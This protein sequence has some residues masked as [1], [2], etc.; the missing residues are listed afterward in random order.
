M[1]RAHSRVVLASGGDVAFGEMLVRLPLSPQD[2]DVVSLCSE[3]AGWSDELLVRP[4]A[5]AKGK[6][7]ASPAGSSAGGSRIALALRMG[8]PR[9][10]SHHVAPSHVAASHVATSHVAAAI[11][12]PKAVAVAPTSHGAPVAVAS[13]A[14]P[15]PV[16]LIAQAPVAFRGPPVAPH[17]AAVTVDQ[18]LDEAR[19]K[20]GPPAPSHHDAA[21]ADPIPIAS[22]PGENRVDRVDRPI[23]AICQDHISDNPA[24]NMCLPCGHVFHAECTGRLRQVAEQQG[25][26]LP[27]NYCSFRCHE[28]NQIQNHLA[29]NNAGGDGA[30]ND[31][32]EVV[33]V[34]CT[35]RI[36]LDADDSG[37]FPCGHRYHRVCGNGP[38]RD[39][40]PYRCHQFPGPHGNVADPSIANADANANAAAVEQD[41]QEIEELF[42]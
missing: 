3:V 12:E 22:S 41:R 25:R 18:L 32:G 21:L 34:F 2:H 19:S 23:C 5:K 31:G 30:S 10:P 38:G 14:V 11:P 35:Q 15:P 40:C 39:L 4:K 13:V 37:S 28:S 9:A 6:A 29:S 42:S 7:I 1:K 8:P 16:A 20:A 33:C 26:Y 36:M 17:R 27:A 24:E